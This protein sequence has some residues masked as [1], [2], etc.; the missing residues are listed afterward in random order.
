MMYYYCDLPHTNHR[1]KLDFDDGWA[2]FLPY[3]LN[4]I[5]RSQETKRKDCATAPVVCVP[6]CFSFF[7][8]ELR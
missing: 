3:R 8:K 1:R 7:E 4:V 5:D 6:I 2:Y